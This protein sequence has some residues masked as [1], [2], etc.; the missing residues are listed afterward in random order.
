MTADEAADLVHRMMAIWPNPAWPADH[1]DEW[2]TFLEDLRVD[3]ATMAVEELKRTAKRRPSFADMN[4]QCAAITRKFAPPLPKAE[5]LQ[6]LEVNDPPGL[7]VLEGAA[8]VDQVN[9]CRRLLEEKTPAAYAV[10]RRSW[11]PAPPVDHADPKHVSV[12]LGKTVDQI[13]GDLCF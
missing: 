3:V 5:H 12:G 1:A 2:L 4:E 11:T 7:P 6:L 13:E 8:V 10:R 9:V